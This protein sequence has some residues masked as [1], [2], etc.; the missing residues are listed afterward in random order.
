MS[1]LYPTS[2]V[3]RATRCFYCDTE[4]E[5][6]EATL[7]HTFG[8]RYCAEHKAAAKRDSK[9]YLHVERR[10]KIKDGLGHD[11]LGPFLRLLASDQSIRRSSGLLEGGWVLSTEEEAP[12]RSTIFFI[13]EKWHIPM[14]HEGHGLVKAVRLSDFETPAIRDQLPVVQAVL[15]DGIYKHDF[16]LQQDLPSSVPEQEGIGYCVVDGQVRR[17]FMG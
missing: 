10:V 17:V 14:V 7:G 9:A 1:F 6:D 2:L 5:N 11:V 13:D 15:D 8:I 16:L 12:E 4:Y 3:M